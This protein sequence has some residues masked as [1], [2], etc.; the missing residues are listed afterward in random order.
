MYPQRLYKYL[1]FNSGSLKA[2]TDAEL[3]FTLPVDFNDPFDCLASYS[4]EFVSQSIKV[5]RNNLYDSSGLKK[6]SPAKK[7]LAGGRA[8]RKA[9]SKAKEGGIYSTLRSSDIGVLSLTSNKDNLLMWSHYCK[10]HTGFVMEFEPQWFGERGDCEN[11][12]V[13]LE[14]LVALKVIYSKERPVLNGKES[15][16][17]RLDKLLLTKSIDWEYE[18]EYRV[19]DHLR[20]GGIHPYKR[21]LLKG[22]Y[23]GAEMR[24]EDVETIKE[25]VAMTNKKHN[26]DVRVF[27][28]KLC[29]RS[30]SLT[31]HEVIL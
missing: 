8:K 28:K 11:S 21:E 29:E 6:L 2:I 25:T 31:E 3:K 12:L 24:S 1:S 4:D 10:N 23:I 9:Q 19:I 13:R 22:V 15:G 18:S 16:Q 27:Q 14:S 26:M 17:D 5:Q 7:L 30:F 20:R